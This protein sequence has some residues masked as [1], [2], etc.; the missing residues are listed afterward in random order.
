MY[1]KWKDKLEKFAPGLVLVESSL[2]LAPRRLLQALFYLPPWISPLNKKNAN[3]V[4][5]PAMVTWD[6]RLALISICQPDVSTWLILLLA[7]THIPNRKTNLNSKLTL[8]IN[9]TPRKH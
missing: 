6:L 8:N 5:F 3:K 2:L 4:S 7:D 9:Q 1:N